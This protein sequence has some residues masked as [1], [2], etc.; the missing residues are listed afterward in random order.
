MTAPDV[1]LLAQLAHHAGRMY[2]PDAADAAGAAFGRAPVCSGPYAF[3]DR[4]EGDRIVL[5]RFVDHW[6]ADQFHYDRVIYLPIPDTTVRLANVRS[7][8]LDIIERT[9]PPTCRACG[10]TTAC[11]CSRCPTSGIRASPSTSATDPRGGTA[12]RRCPRPPGAVAVHRPPGVEPGRVRGE[13][14]VGNQWAAPGTLLR[15]PRSDPRARSDA[16]RA[17]LAE[18]GV[19]TP[20]ASRCRSETTPSPSRSAR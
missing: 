2:S 1:T 17:L 7:G 3:A 12:G 20:S 11:S 4:V 9:A 6:D 8:D 15:R 16:A 10:P 19:Q 5:E 14:V 13:Y 18:A